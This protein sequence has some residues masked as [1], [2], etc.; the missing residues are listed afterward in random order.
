MLQSTGLQ[1]VGHDWVT[2]QQQRAWLWVR[3]YPW[4][5]EREDLVLSLRNLNLLGAL[6]AWRHE[7]YLNMF[8][9]ARGMCC[10]FRGGVGFGTQVFLLAF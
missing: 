5:R 7:T 8:C 9:P 4:S 10:C 6:T 3:V 2:E 1:R